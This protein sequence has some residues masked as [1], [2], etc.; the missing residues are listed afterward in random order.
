MDRRS[1][2]RGL[3]ILSTS[4]LWMHVSALAQG[5]GSL[6]GMSKPP[7]VPKPVQTKD[8]PELI[9]V[10]LPSDWK[11][12][13]PKQWK[14]DGGVLS[15]TAPKS[16]GSGIASGAKPENTSKDLN[17]GSLSPVGQAVPM[18]P[19]MSKVVG[20][21]AGRLKL[22]ALN[23]P[24]YNH[25][26]STPKD[27]TGKPLVGTYT[28]PEQIYESRTF[29]P[30]RRIM[31][32]ALDQIG[33]SAAEAKALLPALNELAV[34]TTPAHE[35]ALPE[36]LGN[37]VLAYSTDGAGGVLHTHIDQLVHELRKQNM[38]VIKLMT[39]FSWFVDKENPT[40][41]TSYAQGGTLKEILADSVGATWHS[42]GYS[43]GFDAKGKPTTVKSDWPT[44]YGALTDKAYVSYNAHFVAIDYQGGVRKPVPA[45]TLSAYYRN[46]D[47]WDVAAALTVP[48]VDE[49][50]DPIYRE[51]YYNPLEGYDRRTL[52]RV[53]NNMAK[54]NKEQFLKQH[55]AFYCSE[56]Q[57][58]VANLG[59]QEYSLVRKRAFGNTALGKLI[60]TFNAAPGY[61]DMPAE[62]RRTNPIIGWNYLKELGAEKGGVSE[63]QFEH[64]EET[65][66]T[67]IY[68]EF[69]PED[70]RGWQSYSPREKEGLIARPMTVATMA[71]SLLRRY[72]PREGIANVISADVMRAYRT[73]NPNVKKAVVALCGS[74]PDTPE[75]QAALASISIRAATGTLI[76]LLASEEIKQLILLK[77]GFAEV[78]TSWDKSKVQRAY[79]GFLDILREADYSSQESLDTALQTADE[80]LSNL[81]VWRRHYNK[82]ISFAYPWR[83]TLMKY[84]A[85]VCFVAWAQQPFMA[86]TGCIRYVTTA[87]NARQAKTSG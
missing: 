46:A 69:I 54:L 55:G 15:K 4:P 2:L 28:R 53:A 18:T 47:L 34:L 49:D 75:G 61:K 51:Y 78:L 74:A 82:K 43:A 11:L 86:R 13:L 62:K 58:T 14:S 17:T 87:M 67:A 16:R 81:K 9:R 57:F 6:K 19:E 31:T 76:G 22:D 80:Q 23:Q 84:A 56:G 10:G 27:I 72:M 45:E 63:E 52:Q 73:G 7:E 50:K 42:G 83:Q 48:F 1:V 26:K 64:V 21:P 70:V 35:F 41:P 33:P 20:T 29:I 65:Q 30:V 8:S 77:G 85:P 68:L 12:D 66:R 5:L 39:L 38:R 60:D 32:A 25:F 59:P 40:A 79:D 3:G 71:W 44:D 36:G 37:R 24:A